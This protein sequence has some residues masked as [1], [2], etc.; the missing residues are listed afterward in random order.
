MKALIL[1]FQKNGPV[2]TGHVIDPATLKRLIFVKTGGV[3]NNCLPQ[4]FFLIIFF[5]RKIA[6]EIKNTNRKESSNFFFPF[7]FEIYS[8]NIFPIKPLSTLY[9]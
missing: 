3:F 7:L 9:I 2:W 8:S 4:F 6:R 5:E 1:G